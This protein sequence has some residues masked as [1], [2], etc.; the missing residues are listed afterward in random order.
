MGYALASVGKGLAVTFTNLLRP[1]TTLQYPDERP[2]LPPRYRG[3]PVVDLSKCMGCQLC[4]RA[5]PNQLIKVQTSR[6]EDGK[7]RKVDRFDI[8]YSLCMLCNLCEEAC[9]PGAIALEGGYEL[10]TTSR[11]Q[12]RSG[13]ADGWVRPGRMPRDADAPAREND[14]N[15]LVEAAA[16]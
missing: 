9:V 8:D 6:R 16:A 15:Q 10:A 4:E 7:G 12:L 13:I 1:K 14:A 3:L 5:C 11:D 2:K